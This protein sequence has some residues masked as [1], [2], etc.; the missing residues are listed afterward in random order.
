MSK[1][2][3]PK[4]QSGCFLFKKSSVSDKYQHTHLRHTLLVLDMQTAKKLWEIVYTRIVKCVV[5]TVTSH[6]KVVELDC[7]IFDDFEKILLRPFDVDHQYSP[8]KSMFH[9]ERCWIK[10]RLP[11]CEGHMTLMNS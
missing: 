6:T 11:S 10:T 7:T 2:L 3:T 4:G 9:C 5:R 1:H 8:F